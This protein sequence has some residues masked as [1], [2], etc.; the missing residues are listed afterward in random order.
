MFYFMLKDFRR[1]KRN[2]VPYKTYALKFQ[3]QNKD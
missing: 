3:T 1:L 2:Y